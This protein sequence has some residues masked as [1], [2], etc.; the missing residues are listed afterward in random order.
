MNKFEVITDI[1]FGDNAL[2]RLSQLEK[3]KAF[4]ISSPVSLIL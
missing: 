3:K 2:E 4:V 1:Y